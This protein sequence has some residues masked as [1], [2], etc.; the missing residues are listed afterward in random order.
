[1]ADLMDMY[2]GSDRCCF[3][4]EVQKVLIAALNAVRCPDA[5]KVVENTFNGDKMFKLVYC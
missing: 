3:P 1:M 5:N 4:G 2:R